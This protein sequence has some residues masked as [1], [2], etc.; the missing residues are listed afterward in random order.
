MGSHNAG[1]RLGVCKRDAGFFASTG[2]VKLPVIIPV[3]WLMFHLCS[4]RVYLNRI[5]E[6]LPESD[7]KF[8]RSNRRSLPAPSFA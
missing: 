4:F 7:K 2:L 5:T 1:E 8:I 3:L 6:N